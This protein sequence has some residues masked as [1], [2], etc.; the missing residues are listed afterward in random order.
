MPGVFKQQYTRA[1]PR[2]AIPTTTRDEQGNDI[3]AVR[4]KG[5]NG[6]TI[7]ALLTEIAGR[8]RVVSPKWYG[9]YTDADGLVQRVALC[10]NKQAA[11]MMLADLV[12]KAALG[13][14]WRGQNICENGL[15]A[16]PESTISRNNSSPIVIRVEYNYLHSHSSGGVRDEKTAA[17]A[18]HAHH[19]LL[20][21]RAKCEYVAV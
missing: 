15:S 12:K 14:R 2:G 17:L 6:K 11:E 1:I 21:G 9:E 7:V 5:R 16:S 10:E 4:F 13:V 8:C 20:C 3:P 18:I 19:R